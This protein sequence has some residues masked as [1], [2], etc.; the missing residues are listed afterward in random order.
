[1]K[2]IYGI[3]LASLKY[4]WYITLPK[5]K[6]YNESIWY[7][8][9]LQSAFTRVVA[10]IS[11]TS[12]NYHFFFFLWG[13][14]LISALL[15]TLKY[16]ILYYYYNHHAVCD[17][18]GWIALSLLQ[19]RIRVLTMSLMFWG[20]LSWN[21]DLPDWGRGNADK[22]KLFFL[23]F[24]THFPLISVLFWGSIISPLDFGALMDD[25]KTG[26]SMRAR[27]LAILPSC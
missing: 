7:N 3:F 2:C 14:H 17:V 20:D 1:M 23:T 22:M 12:H 10:N 18:W 25:C 16:I 11:V 26:I 8:Y 27:V 13:E 15:A 5:F 21:C 6:V 4:Y 9:I 24:G 19:R